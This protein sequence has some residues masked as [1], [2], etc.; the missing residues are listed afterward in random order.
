MSARSDSLPNHVSSARE[1]EGRV[2]RMTASFDG[3]APDGAAGFGRTLRAAYLLSC[4]A[5]QAAFGAPEQAALS[6]ITTMVPPPLTADNWRSHRAE[7]AT[8][9]A[10]FSGWDA[11]PMNAE[12][13]AACP[14]LRV[15]F[16]AGGSVKFLVSDAFWERGIRITSAARANAIPVAE[17]TFAQIIL[18]LKHAW[19]SAVATRVAQRYVR[20]VESI[21]SA[22][23]STVGILSLGVVGRLVAQRLR[24]LD[25]RV[26]GYDPYLTAQDAA[27]LG[28]EC[29][30]LVELFTRADVVT[31]HTPLLPETTHLLREGHFA[32]MKAGATFINTARGAIVHEPELITVLTRRP[33][34]F[35]VLDVTDPEPPVPGSPLYHLPNVL[36]T[37]HLSGSLGAECRRLGVMAIAEARRYLAGE[38]LTGEVFRQDLP[39]VA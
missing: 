35:A 5:R 20:Q 17:F 32:A 25:V 18:G 28:I 36:L 1:T 8:V 2:A 10:I 9:E 7:L 34:L 24:S 12:F 19:R 37:P 13:L 6:E 39:H 14:A 16:H 29:V 3:L 30:G 38:S 21:P 31:C 11:P 15:V 27:A 4:D 33:D 26:I 23:G 22:Y